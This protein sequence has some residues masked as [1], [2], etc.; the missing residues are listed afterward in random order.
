MRRRSADYVIV[1][2]GAAGC[3]LA[4]RLSEDPSVSVLLIEAGGSDRHPLFH[5]PKG[6][7]LLMGRAKNLWAYGVAVMP[8]A[9]EASEFW[10]RGKVL[11]GSTSINGLMYV[12]G[13]AADF[14]GLADR[15]GSDWNWEHFAKA[16]AALESHELGAGP[17]RGGSGPLRIS[18]PGPDIVRPW[19]ETV[20]AAGE[21]MGLARVEDTNQSE[22]AEIIGLSART[23]YHGRRQSAAVAFLRPVRRRPNLT[24]ITGAVVDKVIFEGRCATGVSFERRGSRLTAHANRE[25]ILAAGAM[26]SPGILERSGIGDPD[27]LTPLGIPVLHANRAVGEN[28]LEHRGLMMQWR[29]TSHRYSANRQHHGLRLL[30]AIARY[31]FTGKGVLSAATFDV[32]AWLK[33]RPGANRTD[34]QF[35]LAPH[36]LDFTRMGATTERFPGMSICTYQLR[37]SSAGSVHINSTDPAVLP[38]TSIRYGEAAE[39]RAAMIA[40]VRSLRRLAAQKSLRDVIVEETR[41]GSAYETDDDILRAY[42]EFG[43]CGYHAV[44]SCRMGTDPE[45]VVDPQLHVRGVDGLR[46]VDTSIMPVIPAGNTQGPIMAAAWLAADIIAKTY[47]FEDG[48][49]PIAAGRERMRSEHQP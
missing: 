25:V 40:G 33:S 3:V 34:T 36:S 2:A 11:G 24:I 28:L 17:D 6:V 23:S 1:G 42:D 29:L 22:D 7:P 30:G 5:V 43:T 8:A 10:L 13:R 45:S 32:G 49:E 47:G 26:A 21:E 14:D 20:I 12:R 44:G 35:L 31:V 38:K 4:N 39:D 18:L 46:V 41:P 27:R 19:H 15:A 9:A 37:P 48:K 16:Y